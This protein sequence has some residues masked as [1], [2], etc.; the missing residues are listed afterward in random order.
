MANKMRRKD[1][2]INS[3]KVGAMLSLPSM[4]YAAEENKKEKAAKYV[5]NYYSPYKTSEADFTPHAHNEI[6]LDF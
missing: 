2:I 6:N 5:F 4:A 3:L 1:F